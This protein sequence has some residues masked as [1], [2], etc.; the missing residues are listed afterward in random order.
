MP[1]RDGALATGRLLRVTKGWPGHVLPDVAG[2]GHHPLL[3]GKRGCHMSP[4]LDTV[5]LSKQIQVHIVVKVPSLN[6]CLLPISSWKIGDRSWFLLN[7]HWRQW[8]R[9]QMLREL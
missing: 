2:L 1:E 9:F 7:V 8:F 6:D 4:P 5:H 3:V